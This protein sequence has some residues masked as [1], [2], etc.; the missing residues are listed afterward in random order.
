[1]S[2]WYYCLDKIATK[3]FLDFCPEIFCIFLGASWK[4]FGASCRLP[5]LWYY[6]LSPQE[7]Q[8]ASMKPPG[9]YEKNLGQKSRNNFVGIFVQT[10]KPKGHFEINWPLACQNNL[11]YY[12]KARGKHIKTYCN[13]LKMT[14]NL[15]LTDLKLPNVLFWCCNLWCLA[16]EQTIDLVWSLGCVKLT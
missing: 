7:A 2:F 3:L 12:K 4:L 13:T 1:M 5:C 16:P 14:Q 8:R 6:I 15:A 10:M 11:D 9:S